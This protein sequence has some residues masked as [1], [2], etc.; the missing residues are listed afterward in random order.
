MFLQQVKFFLSV[1]TFLLLVFFT[2]NAQSGKVT[3]TPTPPPEVEDDDTE[4]VFTD[5]IKVNIT[6]FDSR[7]KFYSG[8]RAE[9]LVISENGALHQATS[10]RRVPAN[11]LIVLD[12]GGEDRQA[13]DFK[14]TRETAKALIKNLQTEDS[15]AILE[16][17]DKAEIIAEWTNNKNQL[18]EILN[19]NLKFGRRSQFVEA[20]NLA[21]KFF[22]KSDLE[23]RHLVLISD[24]LDSTGNDQQRA[25]AIK[26]LL[27]TDI[28][29][30]IFS[31]TKL[32]SEV[33][34]QRGKVVTYGGTKRPELPPGADIPVQ[35]QTKNRPIVTINTDRE[36]LKKIKERKEALEKSEKSLTELSESTNGII[37][38]PETHDEMI[39]KTEF[40]AQNI[41]SQY[42]VTYTP[43]R[44]LSEVRTTEER[45]IQITSRRDGLEVLAKR[46]LIVKPEKK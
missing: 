44:A 30:H 11:V 10:V 17:N 24:G 40:L 36:M 6:A 46:K 25:A 9:D 26:N 5:E 2:A 34:Q 29:V 43:K 7:G 23:N 38:L 39:E 13:K 15:V 42:V 33:V 1:T 16:Y 31:Y 35:G 27:T 41:D 19:K 32:E 28:N 37:F 12:T 45:N 21:V 3:P 22:R 20:L 14:T 8:V 18:Y 4:R